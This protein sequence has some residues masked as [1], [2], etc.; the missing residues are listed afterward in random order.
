MG[1]DFSANRWDKV[2]DSHKKWWEGTLERPLIPVWMEGRD[3]GR[4]EPHIPLLSQSTCNDLTISAK[5]I[6]DRIDYELSKQ[7]FLGDAFPYFNMDCF[8]PGIVSAFCGARLD[9]SSGRVWFHPQ[10]SVPISE[11]HLEYDANNVWLN[12]IKEICKEGMNRWQGQVLLGMPD[13]GG[14]LDILAVFRSS[15]ELLMDFYDYPEEVIRLS[16]EIHELWHRFYNEINDVLQPINPGYSDWSTILSDKPSYIP[17]C[18]IAYMI[19]P[20]MFDEFARPELEATFK[21]LERS[22]YHLDGVGQL[23]H[24]DSLLQI[25]ELDVVQ[26]VH[27]DGKPDQ[28]NWPEVYQKIHKAGKKMQVFS[29]ELHCLDAVISQIGTSKGIHFRSWTLKD[30]AEVLKYL[31]KFDMQ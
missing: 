14:V 26:W 18:D 9:N 21:R 19:S 28:A 17:Q 6:I 1:I 30:E 3:P 10:K 16:W 20:G 25:E 8:G 24:L 13:L 15:E 27:G 4:A 23:A 29:G 7:I 5:N 11:I 2:K 31:A 12:R 22:I